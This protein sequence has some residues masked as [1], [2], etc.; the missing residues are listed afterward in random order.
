[1]YI[2]PDKM[3]P[4]RYGKVRIPKE[5]T[6]TRFRPTGFRRLLLVLGGILT[7]VLLILHCYI[8]MALTMAV[9]MSLP[10]IFSIIDTIQDYRSSL[11]ESEFDDQ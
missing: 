8:S 6:Y 1:M 11:Q 3:G 7:I 2:N 9:T 5:W 4:L 10:G